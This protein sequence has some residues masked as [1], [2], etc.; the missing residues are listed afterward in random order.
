MQ[1]GYRPLVWSGKH[2]SLTVRRRWETFF[3]LATVFEISKP[4]M[5][6]LLPQTQGEYIAELFTII[7]DA[8]NDFSSFNDW[9]DLSQRLCDDYCEA[10]ILERARHDN[11]FHGAKSYTEATALALTQGAVVN[12]SKKVNIAVG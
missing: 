8:R 12:S 2:Y 5:E 3:G 9:W 7:N 6:K 11:L 1:V 10:A 4:R